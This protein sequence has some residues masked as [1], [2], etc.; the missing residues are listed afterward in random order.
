MVVCGETAEGREVLG[1]FGVD[2]IV[3]QPTLGEVA[4]ASAA[5]M[6]LAGLLI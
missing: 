2:P 4:E 5:L 1:L 3:S 6:A